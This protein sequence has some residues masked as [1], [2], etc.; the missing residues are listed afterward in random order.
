MVASNTC[1]TGYARPVLSWQPS[2]KKKKARK[3]SEQMSRVRTEETI[4]EL[5]YKCSIIARDKYKYDD[6]Y[7]GLQTNTNNFW[8]IMTK[9]FKTEVVTALR[10]Q[11]DSQ[12]NVFKSPKHKNLNV[13]ILWAKSFRVRIAETSTYKSTST[14]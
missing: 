9:Q 6:A 8:L 7:G 10:R 5:M 12:S 2:Q 14:C 3:S 1:V 11:W 13:P 4:A